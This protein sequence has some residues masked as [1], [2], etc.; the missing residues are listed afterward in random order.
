MLPLV[1]RRHIANPPLTWIPLGSVLH[2]PCREELGAVYSN[3][4]K[5]RVWS[6]MPRAQAMYTVEYTSSQFIANSRYIY[7]YLI[8]QTLQGLLQSLLVFSLLACSLMSCALPC[9]RC[10]LVEVSTPSLIG[11][12]TMYV[13][14]VLSLLVVYC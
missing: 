9:L 2:A 12:I 10:L 8:R 3:S 13:L 7:S 11:F 6:A 1:R 4:G 5:E 14:L